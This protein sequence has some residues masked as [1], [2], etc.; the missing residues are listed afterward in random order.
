LADSFV[1]VLAGETG[2][3]ASILRS[4]LGTALGVAATPA[5]SSSEGGGSQQH[6]QLAGFSPV[7]MLALLSCLAEGRGF[8]MEPGLLRDEAIVAQMEEIC[9]Y[10]SRPQTKPQRPNHQSIFAFVFF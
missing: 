5:S 10:G 9:R 4:P 7:D 2:G 1:V 3:L 6:V 8:H